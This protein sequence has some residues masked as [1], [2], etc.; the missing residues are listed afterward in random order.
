MQTS[1]FPWFQ[2]V[3]LIPHANYSDIGTTGFGTMG[4]TTHKDQELKQQ[5]DNQRK[6]T[7][8]SFCGGGAVTLGPD[9][10]R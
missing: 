10:R 1:A 6:C 9:F 5:A 7:L 2:Q 3:P 8:R 4:L